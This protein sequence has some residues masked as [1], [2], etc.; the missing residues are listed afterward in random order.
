MAL[1]FLHV[2]SAALTI[3]CSGNI[4]SKMCIYNRKHP[5][6]TELMSSS[7]VKAPT[8]HYK[9]FAFPNSGFLFSNTTHCMCSYYLALFT[10]APWELRIRE[11][12]LNMLIL[13]LLLFLWIIHC[14]SFL[15]PE[16]HVFYQ[17]PWNSGRLAC[18]HARR[19]KSK[20]FTLLDTLRHAEHRH[21]SFYW[22]KEKEL[23][24]NYEETNIDDI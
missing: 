3:L 24:R 17:H 16:C 7:R 1:M 6:K 9:R 12:T 5:W 11:W 19:I 4:F 14:Y 10:F 13:W 21:S 15:T 18:Y 8:A 23:S 22:K 2:L 20:T